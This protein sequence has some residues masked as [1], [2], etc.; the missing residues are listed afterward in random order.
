MKRKTIIQIAVI[1][2]VLVAIAAG[3]KLFM[4]K[5]QFSAYKVIR[6]IE[7]QSV[8]NETRYLPFGNYF[9]RYG[10]DGISYLNGES[11]VWN[12][13]IDFRNPLIAIQGNY[14]AVGEQ[15]SNTIYL[16]DTTGLVKE[17]ETSYPMTDLEVSAQGVV[18]AL[19]DDGTSNYIEVTDKEGSQLVMGKTVF[20][21]TGYPLDISISA[22]GTKLAVSYLY[23]NAGTVQGKVAFYNF[24]G[25]GGNA[26]DSLV[27][28]FNQYTDTIVPK[29]DF[30]DNNLAVAFGDNMFSIYK[31][32][33][34]P[35]LVFETEIFKEEIKSVFFGSR[36]IG[37]VFLSSDKEMPYEMKIYDTS[38]KEILTKG[39]NFNYDEIAFSGGKILMNNSTSC[40]IY[41]LSGT[42]E[43]AFT[44]EDEVVC[45]VGTGKSNGYIVVN[46]DS[47]TEIRLK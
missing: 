31:I 29:V 46:P 22:D 25:K 12:Q 24:S 26:Q 18:A 38:G 2:L 34:S 14:V 6:T 30:L 23:L 11:F 9:L 41:N 28:G 27:G 43:F 45:M 10:N 39:F 35:E 8:R 37:I 47:L 20:E 5:R 3:I 15:K 42:K 36:Y 21:G 4:D 17:I 19:L 44:F 32:S 13:A 33:S 40:E 7:T 1:V 16:F